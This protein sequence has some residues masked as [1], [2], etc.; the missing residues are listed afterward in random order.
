MGE[1]E[2]AMISNNPGAVAMGTMRSGLGFT[3]DFNQDANL[4]PRNLK[5][6]S[7]V[8]D[9]LDPSIQDKLRALNTAKTK[10]VESEDFDKAKGLK[11]LIDRL[12]VAGTQL[13]KLEA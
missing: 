5:M 11:E 7:V 8:D 12:R 1:Y 3:G 4:V 13:I 10:A 2:V 6:N 9:S